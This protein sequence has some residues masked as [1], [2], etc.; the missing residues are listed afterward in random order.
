MH[1]LALCDHAICFIV[2]IYF[3]IIKADFILIMTKNGKKD[4]SQEFRYRSSRSM[5]HPM[6][7]RVLREASQ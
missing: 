3:A 5:G 6:G 7:C 4:F 2:Q 1:F